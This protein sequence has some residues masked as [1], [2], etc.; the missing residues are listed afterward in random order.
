M[1]QNGQVEAEALVAIILV[2]IFFIAVSVVV[3]LRNSEKDFLEQ[4]ASALSDCQRIAASITHFSSTQGTGEIYIQTTHDLNVGE[5]LIYVNG[6]SCDFFG[7]MNPVNLV[8]GTVHVFENANG[9]Q[10][11]NA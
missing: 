5:S 11:E 8:T 7:E 10:L 4:Q 2:V 3:F 1:N 9:V 6:F